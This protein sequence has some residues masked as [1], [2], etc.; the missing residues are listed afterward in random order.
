MQ[1]LKNNFFISSLTLIFLL[2]IFSNPLVA[3][4]YYP[5]LVRDVLMGAFNEDGEWE[6]SPDEVIVDGHL[7][8]LSDIEGDET[9]MERLDDDQNIPCII[10]YLTRGQDLA[11]YNTS[12]KIGVSE[13]EEITIHYQ[14]YAI[15]SAAISLKISNHNFDNRQLEVGVA[16]D[17]QNVLPAPTTKTVSKNQVEFTTGHSGGMNVTFEKIGNEWKGRVYL[18]GH[19]IS[20]EIPMGGGEDDEFLISPDGPDVL[21]CG[22]FDLNGDGQMEIV[23]DDTSPDGF[24][25]IF[26]IHPERGLKML[27]WRY[28]GKE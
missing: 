12:G 13:L 23:I 5:V 4:D 8:D 21:N 19:K 9:L 24:A 2:V 27:T 6:E 28:M 11:F 26:S 10:P 22:F 1:K 3:D 15:G 14:G 16:A 17:L 7:V 20:L 25:A 18:M